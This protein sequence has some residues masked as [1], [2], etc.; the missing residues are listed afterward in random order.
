MITNG[1]QRFDEEMLNVHALAFKIIL[2]FESKN[3]NV[4]NQNKSH[5]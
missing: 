3:S 5:K 2:T 1:R 4:K